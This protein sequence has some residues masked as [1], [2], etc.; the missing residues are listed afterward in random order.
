MKN[1]FVR[2]R[3]HITLIWNIK[4]FILERGSK[5]ESGKEKLQMMLTGNTASF[6]RK[7]MSKTQYIGKKL[8]GR[9]I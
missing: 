5:N 2:K 1:G 7:L 3:Y 6:T 4:S 9:L 8:R